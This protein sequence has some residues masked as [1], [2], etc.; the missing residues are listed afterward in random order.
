MEYEDLT[1][2]AQRA[3]LSE[4]G[5]P[6]DDWPSDV[7]EYAREKARERGFH[8]EEINYSGFHSQGDG[9]SWTGVADL[10]EFLEYHVQRDVPHYTELVMLTELVRNLHPDKWLSFHRR[11]FYYSHSG[12]MQ[13]EDNDITFEFDDEE[14]VVMSSGILAGADAREVAD[15]IGAKYLW[16]D[17]E[18]WVLR[19]AKDYADTIYKQLEEEYDNY[20]SEEYFKEL[21]YINGWRFDSAG[22]LI[23]E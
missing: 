17:V 14:P 4:Y 23:Q 6:P 12:T 1:P 2:S 7:Y 21:I 15:A 3:A 5:E 10:L 8:I 9:A 22:K 18:E 16:N 20:T 19:E 13:L 11:S